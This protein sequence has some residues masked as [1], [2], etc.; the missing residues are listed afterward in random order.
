MFQIYIPSSFQVG[1]ILQDSTKSLE[2][3]PNVHVGLDKYFLLGI[4][5]DSGTFH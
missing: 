2:Q 1:K 4:V 3:D 5:G